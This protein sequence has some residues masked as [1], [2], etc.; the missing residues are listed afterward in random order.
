MRNLLFFL[1]LALALAGPAA[2]QVKIGSPAPAT[3]LVGTDGKMHTLRD[4]IGKSWTIVA[5]Y[6]KAHTS[7]CTME[8]K[9]L[10]DESAKIGAYNVVLFGASED[11]PADNASFHANNH[12]NFVLLSDPDHK[13]AKEMGVLMPIG[14][15]SRWTFVIDDKGVI[16]YIDRAV[17]PATAADDL[18]KHLEAL[19][20]P[21]K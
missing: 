21:R 13:L 2:A 5:W 10:T 7:G 15:A 20:V 12:Y 18:I 11:K 1:S 17:N 14:L 6:P 4:A 8:C 16:R 19:H 3:R 9:M